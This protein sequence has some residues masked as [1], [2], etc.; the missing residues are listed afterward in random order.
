MLT[1]NS[2][3]ADVNGK[4]ALLKNKEL[5]AELFTI[6][7]LGFVGLFALSDSRGYMKTYESTEKKLNIDEI[8]D[9]NHDVSLAKWQWM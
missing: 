3:Y 7:F 9:D 8:G 1:E 4:Q 6:N 5:C 2:M